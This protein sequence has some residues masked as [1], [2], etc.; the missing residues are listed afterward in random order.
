MPSFSQLNLCLVVS[1]HCLHVSVMKFQDKFL[2]LRQGNSPYCWNKFQTCCTDMHLIS[3]E[4]CGIFRVFVNF[5]APRPCKISE[6]LC[7]GDLF[8]CI[9]NFIISIVK[10]IY[11]WFQ[12]CVYTLIFRHD[13]TV[14]IRPSW[15]DREVTKHYS[16][17]Q[18]SKHTIWKLL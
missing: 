5:A 12:C 15:F 3:T 7:I 14:M 2:S 16:I 17:L 18:E 6:A 8:H 13:L 10:S 11:S 1:G 9:Q 4:F